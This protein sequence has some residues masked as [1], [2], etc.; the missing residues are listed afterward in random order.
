MIDRLA[1]LARSPRG[2]VLVAVWAWAE[3]VMFPVVPDVVLLPL[4]AAAPRATPR[5]V[6]ALFAG[7]LVGSAILAA[8]V[9]ADPG[10]VASLLASLPGMDATTLPAVETEVASRGV[11]A[12][13]AFGPGVPLKV[14]STAWMVDGGSPV[15]LAVAVLVNRITRIGPGLLIAAAIGWFAP[16]ALRRYERL[17]TVAY[18]LGWIGLYLVYWRIV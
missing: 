9:L 5:L 11:A 16:A 3:A 17:A 10:R 6:L 8:W 1:A 4:I 15:V 12:F 14:Y 7:A 13:A 18:A 2:L